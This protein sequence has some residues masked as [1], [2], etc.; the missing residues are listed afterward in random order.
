MQK[1]ATVGRRTPV[2]GAPDQSPDGGRTSAS[3]G[4]QPASQ[5]EDP[6]KDL[7]PDRNAQFHHISD[8]QDKEERELAQRELP[9][10][11]VRPRASAIC[12]GTKSRPNT[13]EGWGESRREDAGG[14]PMGEVG[15][16]F[17]YEPYR[18]VRRKDSRRRMREGRCG[19]GLEATCMH[20]FTWVP[21][22]NE[23]FRTRTRV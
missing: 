7:H 13:G 22:G 9:R 4:L 23:R 12:L 10:A 5:P 6:R 1:R 11:A 16:G 8:N 14:V 17:V 19:W 18:L 2:H 21:Y 3:D 15:R 20:V